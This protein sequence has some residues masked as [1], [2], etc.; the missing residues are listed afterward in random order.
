MGRTSTLPTSGKTCKYPRDSSVNHANDAW[1]CSLKDLQKT[2]KGSVPLCL[3][4]TDELPDGL[5]RECIKNGISKA[6][7]LVFEIGGAT[8]IIVQI[9]INSWG[10]DVYAKRLSEALASKP[11]PDAVEDATQA[12]EAV[13]E[14]FFHLF[15]SAGKA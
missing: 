11:F 5:F 2:F 14:R 6:S 12:F 7:R 1:T 9:N 8:L 10:R 13:C 3:H 15:G 4:G